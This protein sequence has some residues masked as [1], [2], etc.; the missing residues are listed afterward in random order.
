MLLSNILE[1]GH[2][3]NLAVLWYAWELQETEPGVLFCQQLNVDIVVKD[4]LLGSHTCQPPL[5]VSGRLSLWISNS[6]DHNQQPQT[7]PLVIPLAMMELLSSRRRYRLYLTRSLWRIAL[8]T[9][10][11]EAWCSFH[12]LSQTQIYKCTHLD[13][14]LLT[15]F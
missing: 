3:G 12:G 7:R 13:R 2:C 5:G 8:A 6:R 11:W 10:V 1:Q 14:S 15:M 9:S 4:L